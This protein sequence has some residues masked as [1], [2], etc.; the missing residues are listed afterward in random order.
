MES[1]LQ[2]QKQKF[3][4]SIPH[5]VYQYALFINYA[6]TRLSESNPEMH[7]EGEE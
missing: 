7:E 1:L 5:L 6:S 3:K 4:P 2:C